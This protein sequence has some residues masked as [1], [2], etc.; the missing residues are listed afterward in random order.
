MDIKKRRGDRGGESK[1][2]LPNPEAIMDSSP[3]EPVQGDGEAGLGA[4]VGLHFV[5][6]AGW[7]G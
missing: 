2:S 6:S 4:A 7:Q 5:G 3:G 1:Y